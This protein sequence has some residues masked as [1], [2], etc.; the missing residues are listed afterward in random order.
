MSFLKK[1]QGFSLLEVVIALAMFATFATVFVQVQGTQVG[2][3]GTFPENLK[4]RSLAQKV[5][6]ELIV[7]PPT[8]NESLTAT[9]TQKSFDDEEDYLYTLTW[10]KFTL[11]DFSKLKTQADDP[12]GKS[13][14][15]IEKKISETV[16]KN[17]EKLIWQVDVEIESK[18]SGEK[19]N[20]THWLYNVEAQVEIGGF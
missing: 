6:N 3:S 2:I 9:S 18:L 8:F 20:V 13:A 7:N 14:S 15:A 11:P 10:K 12:E 17:M 19:Y 1:Q 5:V 16:T 4:L